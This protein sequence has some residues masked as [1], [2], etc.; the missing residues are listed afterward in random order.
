M[1]LQTIYLFITYYNFTA[2]FGHAD[3]KLISDSSR[4]KVVGIQIH[5][6]L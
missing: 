1:H 6:R 5:L 3:I 4:T 2:N